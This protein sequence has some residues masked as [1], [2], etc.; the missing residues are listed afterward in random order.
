[1]CLPA[2]LPA[3][4]VA[5]LN[6]IHTTDSLWVALVVTKMPPPMT[7]T[8][9]QRSIQHFGLR[10]IVSGPCSST[11]LCSAA[12]FH[13]LASIHSFIFIHSFD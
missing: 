8:V 6:I 1:M 5:W 13:S 10:T 2:C 3:C 7:L 12:P 11:A 4:L 9:H